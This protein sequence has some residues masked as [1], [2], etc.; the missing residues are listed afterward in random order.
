MPTFIVDVDRTTRHSYRVE[1]VD[2]KEE[3]AER[4]ADHGVIIH[5]EASESI[6]GV[7]AEA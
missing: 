1:D 3:A 7:S 5:S 2:S 4:Y 6:A